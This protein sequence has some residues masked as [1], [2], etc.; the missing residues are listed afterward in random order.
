[1]RLFDDLTDACQEFADLCVDNE[2][3]ILLGIGIT[4][5]VG[6]VV[7]T[8][9]VTTKFIRET[10]AAKEGIEEIKA[11]LIESGEEPMTEKE[12]T[13]LEIR[14]YVKAA[15]WYAI[16]TVL[17]GIGLVCIGKSHFELKEEVAGWAASYV[18]LDTVFKTYRSRVVEDQGKEKDIEYRYGARKELIEEEYT[19]EKGRKKKRTKEELVL[20]NLDCSEFAKFFDDSCKGFREDPEYNMSYLK[21]IQGRFN[22]LIISRWGDGTHG[23]GRVFLNEVYDAFNIQR[24]AK[25][26]NYGW[27]YDPRDFEHSSLC[28]IDFGIVKMNRANRR[29]VNGLEP[30][31]LMDFNCELLIKDQTFVHKN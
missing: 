13:G 30:V 6:A 11:D 28:P 1:M 16:P 20:D 24:T 27:V 3:D 4:A 8:G 15:R 23:P 12:E 7:A 22:D 25:G 14:S 10:D 5:V 21:S 9:I 31:V 17:L 18:A 2:A 19:D 29:F 26:W